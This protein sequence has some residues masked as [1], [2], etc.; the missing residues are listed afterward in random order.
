MIDDKT[1]ALITELN[2]LF[3]N[4]CDLDDADDAFRA[5]FACV[6]VARTIVTE[7]VGGERAKVWFQAVTDRV[8]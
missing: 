8:A 7:M 2:D 1:R 4:E 5:A 6:A 3:A